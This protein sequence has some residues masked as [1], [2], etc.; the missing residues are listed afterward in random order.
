[1]EGTY[2]VAV[3][4]TEDAAKTKDY[5]PIAQ[6]SLHLQSTALTCFTGEGAGPKDWGINADAHL[7]AVVTAGGTVVKAFGYQ[8]INETDVPAVRE[9]LRKAVKGKSGCRGFVHRALAPGVACSFK[10]EPSP[11]R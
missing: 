5:L 8:S 2:V 10:H 4:L 1:V 11:C 9:A 3:W 6:K 7:T